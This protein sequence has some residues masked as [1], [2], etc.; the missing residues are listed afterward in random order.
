MVQAMARQESDV[1]WWGVLGRAVRATGMRED[2]DGRGRRAPGRAERRVSEWEPCDL[3]EA[4]QVGEAGATDY[5][6]V[7]G[8]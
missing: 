8:A 2:G 5:G 4:G 7:D 3:R 6:D 1:E